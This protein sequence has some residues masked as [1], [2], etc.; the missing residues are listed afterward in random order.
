MDQWNSRDDAQERSFFGKTGMVSLLL[1]IG[2]VL[3]F[4]FG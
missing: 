3:Y 2:F 4:F 1:V